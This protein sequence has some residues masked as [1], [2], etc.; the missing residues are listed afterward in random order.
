ML[1]LAVGTLLMTAMA[2][3]PRGLLAAS[4]PPVG[5]TTV[6]ATVPYPGHPG[7]IA[8]DG[9]TVYVDTFNPIVRAT[10]TYDAIFTYD[11]DTG[12]LRADRPRMQPAPDGLPP[13]MDVES[14]RWLDLEVGADDVSRTREFASSR[15]HGDPVLGARANIEIGS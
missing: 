14:F 7:G 4:Q 11:L 2:V 1:P 3:L 8:V 13:A 15:I 9:R 5:E 6:L 10:D 12:R